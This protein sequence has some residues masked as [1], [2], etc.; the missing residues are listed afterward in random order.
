VERY[1]KLG[2]KNGVQLR[3][4]EN[5]ALRGLIHAARHFDEGKG[6]K[7]STYASSIIK[8]YLKN[9]VNP[10]K[11]PPAISMET[12]IPGTDLKVVQTLK[13]GGQ[14]DEQE[15]HEEFE[16]AV[17]LLHGL[18][19]KGAITDRELVVFLLR[20]YHNVTLDGISKH[21]E[22]GVARERVRQIEAKAQELIR[23]NVPKSGRGP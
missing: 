15:T 6:L 5:E 14:F 9:A 17:E 10:P 4:L 23:K 16:K 13:A 22:F 3:E 7:F 19:R 1:A 2:E 8:G 12:T 20:K 11:G 21:P 18:H